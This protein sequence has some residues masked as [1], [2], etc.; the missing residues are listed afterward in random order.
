[1]LR[2]QVRDTIA[3]DQLIDHL[4]DHHLV[5]AL[6]HLQDQAWAAQAEDLQLLLHQEVVA[7][8]SHLEVAL[9]REEGITKKYC[10][11]KKCA[12]NY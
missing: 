4:Q 5:R 10:L 9:D 6:D 1:M 3:A 8:E 2:D 12:E 11:H 7:L